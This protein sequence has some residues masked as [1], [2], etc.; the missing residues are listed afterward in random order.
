VD[1][2]MVHLE[3]QPVT[4]PLASPRDTRSSGGEGALP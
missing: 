1:L 2:G 4:G 3:D